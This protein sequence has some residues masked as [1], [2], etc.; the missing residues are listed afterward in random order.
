M[1]CMGG[2]IPINMNSDKVE[3][4]CLEC[5]R[6][7]PAGDTTSCKGKGLLNKRIKKEIKE[8]EDRNADEEEIT[9]CKGCHCMTKTIKGVCGKC[10][11]TE[12]FANLN[13]PENFDEGMTQV[14]K[15]FKALTSQEFKRISKDPNAPINYD[16]NADLDAP[17]ENQNG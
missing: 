15:D 1:S 9:Q 14:G 5:G 7:Y 10:G 11:F 17:R 6:T 12:R 3:F 4:V 13:N 16:T 8:I 2:G